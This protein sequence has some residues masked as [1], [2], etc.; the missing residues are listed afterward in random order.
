MVVVGQFMLLYM[1]YTIL[2]TGLNRSRGRGSTCAAYVPAQISPSCGDLSV[3]FSVLL[4]W[5]PSTFL[6][7]STWWGGGGMFFFL[8]LFILLLS[9]FLMAL[10]P[11]VST[12]FFYLVNVTS[13][14]KHTNKQ[15]NK[16][17]SWKGVFSSLTGRSGSPVLSD[18]LNLRNRTGEKRRRQTFRDKRENNCLKKPSVKLLDL[19]SRSF[20]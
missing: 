2:K 14:K 16:Q 11:L 18:S 3:M 13:W 19:F 10:F 5:N 9:F 20:C 7:I 1:K 17:T 4:V 15:I 8:L 12:D 6:H